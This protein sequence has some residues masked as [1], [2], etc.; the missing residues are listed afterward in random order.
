MNLNISV[1][2]LAKIIEAKIILNRKNEKIK[3]FVT[4]SRKI[5]HGEIFWALKGK[6]FDGNDF[7]EETIKKEAS[8]IISSR[9]L[10]I[11][12]PDTL[13][14]YLYTENTLES[15]FKLARW[16]L[17]RFNIKKV[18]ITGSNG[19]T[20]TKEMIKDIL[21]SHKPTVYN[22]GNLNNEYGLPICVLE[23]QKKHKF[24]VFEIGSSARGEVRKLASIINP[25]I[26][27]ITIISPEHLE[28]FKTMKN[29]FETETEVIDQ[30]N[31]N[32]RIIIN[33][34]NK[35]L[36]KLKKFKN[37]ISFGFKPDNDLIISID[38]EG[39]IFKYKNRNHRIKLKNNIKHNYL[40][41]A[42]GFITGK[43]LRIPETKIIN[44]LEIFEG[45]PLR[46]QIIKRKNS[47]II[48]DAYNANP[49]SMEC[50][51]EEISKKKNFAMILGDMKELGKY[52]KKYHII[53][54]RKILNKNPDYLFLIGQEMKYAYDFLKNK[55][56]NVKYYGDTQDALLEVK[57]FIKDNDDLN[58]LIKA[59][60]SM[61]F[62]EFLDLKKH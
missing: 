22:P 6:N 53:I 25:D 1:K 31:K 62:E 59:S 4:D 14:F 35:Y 56:K 12:F 49:Q 46:M 54:A 21:S 41:A 47:E 19:K 2:E 30:M 3:S 5:K 23:S 24:A 61:K 27:V 39:A 13:S 51:I 28:F 26:A 8:G 45:V 7:I 29:I 48:L 44:S 32:G 17:K 38:K 18:S 58:I 33:G 9:I 34:D 15:L 36:K 40:N 57:K 37:T 42:A 11:S 55:L 60:R 10:S 52:S 16:H 50:A 20:T 43:I